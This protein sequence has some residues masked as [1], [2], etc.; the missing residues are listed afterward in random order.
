MMK[1]HFLYVSLINDEQAELAKRISEKYGYGKDDHAIVYSEAFEKLPFKYTLDF[2]TLASFKCDSYAK[3]MECAIDDRVLKK[4]MPYILQTFR[5]MERYLGFDVTL[6]TLE[7]L[8]IYNVQFWAAYLKQNQIEEVVFYTY[9]HEGTSFIIYQ[10]C[11]ALN[12]KTTIFCLSIVPQRCYMVRYLEDDIQVVQERYSCLMKEYEHVE[13]EK[14]ELHSQYGEVFK[15]MTDVKSEKTPS[16]MQ[17]KIVEERLFWGSIKPYSKALQQCKVAKKN[18]EEVSVKIRM[19]AVICK[20]AC[21]DWRFSKGIFFRPFNKILRMTRRMRKMYDE[22]SIEAD[23][24]QKYIY[25]PLHYQPECTS[26]PQGGGLYY[27]QAIPIRILAESL[28]NDF[29]IYVKEHPTQFYGA[30]TKEFYEELLKIP[31]V[32]LVKRATDTY[33]LIEN[34]VAVASLTGTAG[35]EG[36]F[37]GKPFIMFGYWITQHMPGVFH[38]RTK[39]ECKKAIQRILIQD[40]DVSR[41]SIKLF[42]KTLEETEA[43]RLSTEIANEKDGKEIRISSCF[44]MYERFQIIERK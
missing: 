30:R 15:K 11:R 38:V 24:G 9:P 10:V 1:R 16:Y 35:W 3:N 26:N 6:A 37:A 12:I 5:M 21:A 7:R 8:Y 29:Y 25:F 34:C 43:Y 32:R 23:F 27:E 4:I 39:D 31:K 19:M 14:I 2:L 22:V 33:E 18:N 20:V 36:V 13:E 40:F 42:F 41:K 28:P 44:E 17:K